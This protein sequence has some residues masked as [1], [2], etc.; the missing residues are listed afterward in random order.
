MQH[1]QTCPACGGIEFSPCQQVQPENLQRCTSCHLVFEWRKPSDA[2]L[3]AHY[4]N[5]SYS[6]LRSCPPATRASFREV[7]KSF[8][9][10][11][12]ECRLLDI[13]CGQG[14]F[15]IEANIS[16]WRTSGVEFS[17]AAVALCQERKLHVLMAPSALEAFRGQRFDVVTAFEVLEHLRSPGDIFKDAFELLRSGGLFYLTTPNFNSILRY[18]EGDKFESVSFPDHLSLFTP[19]SLH[20][21]AVR[22]GFSVATLRTTGLDPWRLKKFF[23]LA[24]KTFSSPSSS[25]HFTAASRSSLREAA[26]TSRRVALA[27]ATV[28]S[29]VNVLGAGDTLKARLVKS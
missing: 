13:G 2:E 12:G 25:Q 28:N 20:A 26:F 21:L 15:L 9:P 22:H 8:E 6:G 16:K 4:Q 1:H 27:K 24:G 10:W 7:L 3:E 17:K 19:K 11:R 5:Y 14:D 18:L 23:Q 29:F